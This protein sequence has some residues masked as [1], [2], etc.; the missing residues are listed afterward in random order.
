MLDNEMPCGLLIKLEKDTLGNR[1]MGSNYI[2]GY[3]DR[4]DIK[5]V[6]HWFDFSPKN[7]V[8]QKKPGDDH[9]ISSYPIK[10]IFPTRD[11]VHELEQDGL[12]YSSWRTTEK[13]AHDALEPM[14]EQFPCITVVL[15]NLTDEF[16]GEFPRDVCSRQLKKL[17]AIMAGS[18]L[19]GSSGASELA[20]AHCCILPSLG[21]S[22]YCILFAEEEWKVAPRFM[23]YLHKATIDAGCDKRTPV[24]STDYL[25]PVYHATKFSRKNRLHNHDIQLS[26]RINLKPGVSMGQLATAMRDIAEVHQISGSSDC[27]LQAKSGKR[28]QLLHFL[29]PGSGENKQMIKMVIQTE[30]FLQRNILPNSAESTQ[31]S[32]LPRSSVLSIPIRDLREVLFQYGNLIISSG[33]HM[34]QLNALNE[35]VTAIEN[36]CSEYHNISLQL[37][38]CEWISAFTICLRKCI[39]GIREETKS[40]PSGLQYKRIEQMWQHTEMTLE[41]F[42]SQV[43][44]FLADLSRSDC[45]FME[46]EQYNHPSVSSATALLIAYNHWQ[47]N[48]AKDVLV[49]AG[50]EDS[51]YSFLVRSGGCDS[52]HTNNLFW[53]LEPELH[54]EKATMQESC[55]LVIQMSEMSLFDCGGT[56]FRMTHECMHFCG[57]R[58]RILRAKYLIAFISRFYAQVLA[59]VLF[60]Q[61]SYLRD[62]E[63]LLEREFYLKNAELKKALEKCWLERFTEFAKSIRD[64]FERELYTELQTDSQNWDETDYLSSNFR[65]WLHTKLSI[66]FSCY[67]FPDGVVAVPGCAASVPW[68]YNHLAAFLYDNQLKTVQAFYHDCDTVIATHDKTLKV[69]ALEQ[70]RLEKYVQGISTG[71]PIDKELNQWIPII[72]TQL[73][74]EQNH[75]VGKNHLMR[76]LREYGVNRVL[77]AVVFECF[78]EAFADLEACLR[79]KASLSDYLLGF[80]FEIWDVRKAL[81]NRGA[82]VY[83]IPSILRI[84]FKNQLT[85]DG[86]ALTEAA[87]EELGIALNHLV[88]HGMDANRISRNKLADRVDELLQ[89]YTGHRWEAEALERYLIECKEDYEQ[90]RLDQANMSRYSNAFKAIR[91]SAIEPEADTVARLFTAL[92]MIEQR[93]T[94]SNAAMPAACGA[95]SGNI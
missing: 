30:A 53:F 66:I 15:I 18:D 43:G 5:Q 89:L 20:K 93:G 90:N 68:G 76:T 22:D 44:S 65:Q 57:N 14:F 23:E 6:H 95:I 67:Q 80:V 58:K 2:L 88:C 45:F 27:L 36:I 39:K 21:Y 28:D 29:I 7:S 48:F 63:L 75:S 72:L 13:D 17:A 61:K 50:M 86:R 51:T 38:M 73:L 24:L 25:M 1:C 31:I 60:S 12:D 55:P 10:L 64:E 78:S 91:L 3:Y 42:I 85:A 26:V 62:L 8:P 16:K 70:R 41:H 35:R 59:Q 52:T 46:S 81:S 56:V 32:A 19:C 74:I 34:R 71:N 33:R 69:F 49:G 92:S 84:C 37:I 94:D 82:Y 4:L 54:S 9:P 47:N 83:R 79:L 87:K 11:V 77:T 40:N